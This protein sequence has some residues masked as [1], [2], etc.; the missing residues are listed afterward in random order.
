MFFDF[1]F[2]F[3][4]FSFCSFDFPEG[5][6]INADVEAD[7]FFLEEFVDFAAVVSIVNK[8]GFSFFLAFKVDST[9]VSAVEFYGE[10]VDL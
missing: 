9:E 4:S 7:I 1:F 6:G 3:S 10:N 8:E 2:S 5:F